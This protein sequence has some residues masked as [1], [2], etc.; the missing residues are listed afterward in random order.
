MN[1]EANSNKL[2]YNPHLGDRKERWKGN[3]CIPF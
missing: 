3:P 2:I 1:I